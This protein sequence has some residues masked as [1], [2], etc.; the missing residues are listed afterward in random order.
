M[1]NS[2]LRKLTLLIISN[3]HLLFKTQAIFDGD[4]QNINLLHMCFIL[5]QYATTS[6]GVPAAEDVLLAWSQ[7]SSNT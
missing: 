5:F 4:I 2:A 7:C 3:G 6:S 1:N